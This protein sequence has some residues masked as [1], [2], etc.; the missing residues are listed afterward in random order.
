MVLDLV[1]AILAEFGVSETLWLDFAVAAA[2]MAIQL[3]LALYGFYAIRSFEKYTVPLTVAVMALMT[4][5]AMATTDVDWTLS[6]TAVEPGAKFTAVT[7]LL[8]AIG[9]GWGLTW[10]PYASDYSRFVRVGATS[11]A[12]FWSSALGHVHPDRVAGRTRRLPRER[13]QWQRPIDAWWSA[14]SA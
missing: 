10:I 6:G 1:L 9:I 5:L 8:T 13:R 7:Q 12:V 4:V 11:R 3:G 14:H 2:I